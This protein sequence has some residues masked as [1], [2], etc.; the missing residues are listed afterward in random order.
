MASEQ[1]LYRSETFNSA[2][3]LW[4]TLSPSNANL[5]GVGDGG[6]KLDLIFRGLPDSKMELV[7][8]ALRDNDISRRFWHSYWGR[9]CQVE[10]QLYMETKALLFFAEYA[11]EAGISIPGDFPALRGRLRHDTDIDPASWPQTEFLNIMA[12][13]QHHGVSTRLLDWTYNPYVAVYF[14][15]SAALRD[16]PKFEDCFL[17]IWVKRVLRDEKVRIVRPPS[18]GVS[19]RSAAQRSVF[20]VHPPMTQHRIDLLQT[21]GLETYPDFAN[22]LYKWTLPISESLELLRMCEQIGISAATV[23]PGVE[24]VGKATQERLLRMYGRYVSENEVEDLRR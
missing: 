1:Q 17:A 19:L 13:A 2:K 4:E 8:A 9:P 6:L 18:P 16:F 15:A 21:R 5:F 23:F 22:S 10:H 3:D 20:T 12:L 11:D 7:P 24:G 14:A